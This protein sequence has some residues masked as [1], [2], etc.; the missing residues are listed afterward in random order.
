MP[1]VG[2][3]NDDRI[4]LLFE[5][6]A[7]VRISRRKVARALSDR[8]AP[9]CIDI[10]DSGYLVSADLVGSVQK[11]THASARADDSDTQQIV[12]TEDSC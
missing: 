1:M 10:A 11:A 4:E 6:L 5:K 2:R 8:I 7:I 3:G 9:G 12:G